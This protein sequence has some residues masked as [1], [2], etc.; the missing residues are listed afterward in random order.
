M[1][2][3]VGAMAGCSKPLSGTYVDKDKSEKNRIAELE[4]TIK[5]Q[6]EEIEQL[7]TKPAARNEDKEI[8]ETLRKRRKGVCSNVVVS[9]GVAKFYFWGVMN[10]VIFLN[11]PENQLVLISIF[12]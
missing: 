8:A 6:E 2:A 12:S 7:R 10:A 11:D 9:D 3:F 1:I 4:E 5:R